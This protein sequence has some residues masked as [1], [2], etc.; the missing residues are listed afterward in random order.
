MSAAD[1]RALLLDTAV[2]S[3][4]FDVAVRYLPAHGDPVGGDW[5]DVFHLPDGSTAFFGARRG[6]AFGTGSSAWNGFLGQTS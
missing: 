6:E 1:A 3:T 5:H 2:T 4:G